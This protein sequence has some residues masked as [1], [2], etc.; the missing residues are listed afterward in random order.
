MIHYTIWGNVPEISYEDSFNKLK[1][2][3][4]DVFLELVDI[5]DYNLKYNKTKA[6][7]YE[8]NEVPLE[9]Y[10]TYDRLQIMA[11]F[12]KTTEVYKYPSREGVM[13]LSEKN[14][15]I[16]WVTINKNEEDY[17]PST[18]YNDYAIN[19]ELFHWESQ[20][21]T[22]ATSPTGIRYITDTSKEHKVLFFVREIGKGSPYVFLGNAKYVSHKGSN[23]IQIIWKME[24]SIPEK[25]I[26]SSKL[27]VLV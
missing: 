10:A 20:S 22:S 18:M 13:F 17:I 16:F 24:H 2:D 25:I 4:Q 14:T 23:P 21:T 12:G 27:K 8:D 19:N 11:A 5:L 26:S 15:D 6:L 7:P 3:N 1:I 9:L